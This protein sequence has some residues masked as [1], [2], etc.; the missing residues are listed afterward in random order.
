MGDGIGFHE[1]GL[2]DIPVGGSDGDVGAE[3][4]AGFGGGEA[5]GASGADRR[6]DAVNS[7]SADG[8]QLLVHIIR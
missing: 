3:E 6:Q 7:S 4:A 8:Q 1:S 2:G 5:L